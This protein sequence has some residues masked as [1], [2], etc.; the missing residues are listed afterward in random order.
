MTTTIE[1]LSSRLDEAEAERA[2]LLKKIEYLTSQIGYYQGKAVFRVTLPQA[3]KKQRISDHTEATI[4]TF[5]G[6]TFRPKQILQTLEA[7]SGLQDIHKDV[8]KTYVS[9]YLWDAVFAGEIRK[10]GHGQYQHCL[11]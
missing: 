7:N 6:D 5:G 1:T 9:Q 3:T 4:A 2:A 8:K 10:V 11:R